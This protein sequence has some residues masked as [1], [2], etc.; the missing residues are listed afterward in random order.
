MKFLHTT[1]IHLFLTDD[2][3]HIISNIII[4]IMQQVVEIRDKEAAFPPL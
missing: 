1:H 2:I 4:I 3:Y